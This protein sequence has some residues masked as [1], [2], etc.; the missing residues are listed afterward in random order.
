MV[1]KMMNSIARSSYEKMDLGTNKLCVMYVDTKLNDYQ[2]FFEPIKNEFD[3]LYCRSI[4]EAFQM[5]DLHKVDLILFDMMSAH[6]A[7]VNE[8]F[9]KFS[10]K[11]PIIALSASADPKIAYT[12]AKLNAIDFLHK[13]LQ[14]FQQISIHIHRNQAEWKKNRE[15]VKNMVLLNDSANRKVIKDLINTEL[16]I[17]Q[18]ISS[19]LITEINLNEIVKNSYGIQST[20]VINRNPKIMEVL[21]G[22]NLVD[23]VYKEQ[24]LSCPNCNSVNLFAHYFCYKCKHSQFVKRS[25][26]K[27]IACNCVMNN[28]TF[29]HDN[30]IVCTNCM[31]SINKNSSEYEMIYNYECINCV[32]PFVLPSIN[33]SCNDCN[34]EK[35]SL[36][37][38]K[39]TNLF[40]F[41]PNLKNLKRV[42]NTVW[43][44]SDLEKYLEEQG[45]Q[46]NKQDK[47]TSGILEHVTL[48]LVA[49]KDNQILF[50]TFLNGDIQQDIKQILE[51]EQ[52]SKNIG[53]NKILKSFAIFVD[54]PQDVTL[55]ILEKCL[56]IPLIER[57][58]LDIVHNIKAHI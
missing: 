30:F 10:D 42:R 11:I 39:W 5:I 56:I 41:N 29:D 14:N 31:Q 51:V 16:P 22:M 27:H 23:K 2:H 44:F 37:E 58:P 19:N 12:A 26:I 40:Q 18:R 4:V 7:A 17:T 43:M 28:A 50:F 34:L 1:E 8:F 32:D 24:T 33:Y 38:G 36:N 21:A 57:K 15:E 45:F 54:E 3:F 53:R 52:A 13:G 35:F 47:L 6:H 49:H 55:K 25:K 20:D 48:E 46:V 9:K